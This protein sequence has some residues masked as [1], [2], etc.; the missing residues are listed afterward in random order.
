MALLEPQLKRKKLS[1][2]DYNK[3]VPKT[4]RYTSKVKKEVMKDAVSNNGRNYFD[5]TESR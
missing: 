1:K 4:P 5:R 3:F 2:A